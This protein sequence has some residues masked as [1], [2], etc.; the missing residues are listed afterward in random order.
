MAWRVM[1]DWIAAQLALAETKMV[2][3]DE[4]MLPYMHVDDGGTTVL[5]NYRAR[6]LEMTIGDGW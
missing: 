2:Q 1:K 4:I 6:A 3:L 5:D